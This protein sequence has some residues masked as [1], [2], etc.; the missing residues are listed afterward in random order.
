MLNTVALSATALARSSSST[1]STRNAASSR[2]VDCENRTE[3]EVEHN[4]LPQPNLPTER[5]QAEDGRLH[6]ESDLRREDQF[7]PGHSVDQHAAGQRNRNHRQA[8]PGSRPCPAR[9]SNCVIVVDQPALRHDLHRCADH[10]YQLPGPEQAKITRAKRRSKRQNRCLNPRDRPVSCAP[11]T[12][13]GVA[14]FRF[15][16][17]GC[18]LELLTPNALNA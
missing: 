18:L 8:A 6:H 12:G 7:A 4:H 10:G 15:G 16:C 9:T 11:G 2:M 1:S 14:T 5:Q 17:H 13:A 3:H